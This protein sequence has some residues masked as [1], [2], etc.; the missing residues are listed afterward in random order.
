MQNAYLANQGL[1]EDYEGL[2]HSGI[3]HPT[4]VSNLGRLYSVPCGDMTHTVQTDL[5]IYSGFLLEAGFVHNLSIVPRM[6]GCRAIC[7][8]AL[9]ERACSKFELS[10]RARQAP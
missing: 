5:K 4:E 1:N 3:R 9:K 10:E 7:L 2:S 6:L 8:T